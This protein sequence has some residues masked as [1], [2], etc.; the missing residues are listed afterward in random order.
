MSMAHAVV[1]LRTKFYS[2]HDSGI[3]CGAN[4]CPPRAWLG[5]VG[6]HIHISRPQVGLTISKPGR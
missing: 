4:V 1:L 5:D 3:R 6:V 2:A